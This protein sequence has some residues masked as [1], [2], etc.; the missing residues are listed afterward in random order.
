MEIL[1]NATIVR[2]LSDPNLLGNVWS[3]A[4]GLIGMVEFMEEIKR[5]DEEHPS[6]LISDEDSFYNYIHFLESFSKQ[7]SEDLEILNLEDLDRWVVNES[8]DLTQ[9]EFRLRQVK[10]RAGQNWNKDE[11]SQLHTDLLHIKTRLAEIILNLKDNAYMCMYDLESMEADARHNANNIVDY[12]C[13][14]V[15]DILSI[16]DRLQMIIDS[17]EIMLNPQPSAPTPEPPIIFH[18]FAILRDNFRVRNAF[19]YAIEMGLMEIEGAYFKWLKKRQLLAYFCMRVSNVLIP[20]ADTIQ[21]IAFNRM[22]IAK[23]RGDYEIETNETLR[24][25]LQ[26]YEDKTRTAI[27]DRPPEGWESVEDIISEVK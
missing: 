23:K 13:K 11:A 19:E 2:N 26:D 16:Q 3:M 5:M 20:D 8:T 17:A 4:K 27:K 9:L 18:E 22:F 12:V 15:R 25:C 21:W 7:W 10:C 6:Q 24:R 1:D 14:W